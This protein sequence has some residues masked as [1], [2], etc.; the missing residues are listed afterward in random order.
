MGV[1]V[2]YDLVFWDQ[3]ESEAP[4]P[5]AVYETLLEGQRIEGLADLPID[6]F[7]RAI[8]DGFPGAVRE[9]N[10]DSE[11]IV[12]TAPGEKAMFEVWWSNQYVLASCRGTSNE[13]MNRLIDIAVDLGC[14]LSDPQVDERFA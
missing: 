9:P 1:V 7:L 10:G 3:R 11:L 13:D 8:L 12:W 5:R 6:D 14:R 4:P 2:S